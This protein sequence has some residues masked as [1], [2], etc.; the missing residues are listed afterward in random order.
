MPIRQKLKDFL[1]GK[2][3]PHHTTYLPQDMRDAQEADRPSHEFYNFVEIKGDQKNAQDELGALALA[4]GKSGDV[5]RHP[6]PQE[7][8]DPKA[9]FIPDG[10]TGLV[11][12]IGPSSVIVDVDGFGMYHFKPENLKQL[13]PAK[14]RESPVQKW[15]REVDPS[16][17]KVRDPKLYRI[18]DLYPGYE[19]PKPFDPSKLQKKKGGQGITLYHGSD[20][21]DIKVFNAST[22][23]RHGYFGS[24]LYTTPNFDEAAFYGRYVYEGAFNGC[25]YEADNFT[26][27]ESKTGDFDDV[28]N[29][30]F[31][32]NG[33]CYTTES[34]DNSVNGTRIEFNLNNFLSRVAV[35]LQNTAL[36]EAY[37]EWTHNQIERYGQM[38]V[39]EIAKFDAEEIVTEWIQDLYGND[40]TENDHLFSQ[41]VLHLMQAVSTAYGAIKKRELICID[42]TEIGMEVLAAGF[43]A[44]EIPGLEANQ[45]HTEI[46]VFDP[47][48]FVVH[49]VHD[50]QD[51]VAQRNKQVKKKGQEDPVNPKLPDETK[52]SPDW[53]DLTTPYAVQNERR[54]LQLLDIA[55]TLPTRGKSNIFLKEQ[56]VRATTS[57]LSEIK[58]AYRYEKALSKKYK[59][60]INLRTSTGEVVTDIH[61]GE[62]KSIVDA[63]KAYR[64]D[65]WR[66]A[67][68][69]LVNRHPDASKFLTLH[70]KLLRPL[71][72]RELPKP[73]LVE[74]D[75]PE[76]LNEN[77]NFTSLPTKNGG[78]IAVMERSASPAT[79]VDI[80][81][82]VPKSRQQEVAK[83]E[84]EVAER[85]KNGE[86]NVFYYW[87]MSRMP[88]RQPR[89]IYFVEDGAIRSYHEV[90]SMEADKIWMSP[91][92][93]AITPIPMK[94]FQGYRWFDGD[95][96]VENGTNR[97]ATAGHEA[98]AINTWYHGDTARRLTFEDQR[99]QSADRIGGNA[100]GPGIYF[101]DNKASANQYA[102]PNGY[103]YTAIIHGPFITTIQPISRP[104]LRRFLAEL[105]SDSRELLL[106]NWDPDPTRAEAEVFKTYR[107]M[108]IL[109]ALADLGRQGGYD[110]RESG[111]EWCAMMAR[112]TGA[113]GVVDEA[114]GHLSVWVPT[115]ITIT[116][117]EPYV[118]E[119]HERLATQTDSTTLKMAEI[120]YA[121]LYVDGLAE[122]KSELSKIPPDMR[123]DTLTS[124]YVGAYT[125]A[126]YAVFRYGHRWADEV[127]R[128]KEIPEKLF[129]PVEM[130]AR[131]FARQS[132]PKEFLK[133]FRANEKRL[134]LLAQAATWPERVDT[135]QQ[136]IVEGFE[137]HNT[138]GTSG[139]TLENTMEVI[140]NAAS[141]C[142]PYGVVYG[143]VYLV[144]QVEHANHAAW[145]KAQ[146]DIIYLRPLVK[147]SS[148]AEST[149]HLIHELGHR[150]WEKKLTA[151]QQQ[152]WTRNFNSIKHS[153]VK[154]EPSE[155]EVIPHLIVNKRKV[156]YGGAQAGFVS[157]LDAENGQLLGKV[158]LYDFSKWMMQVG[159]KAQFPTAYSSTSAEEYFAEAFSLMLTGSTL[160]EPHLSFLQKLFSPGSTTLK[161][162][163][164][165]N[166]HRRLQQ[167]RPRKQRPVP[168]PASLSEYIADRPSTFLSMEF[169][170]PNI[171][172][173]HLSSDPSELDMEELMFFAQQDGVT[174]VDSSPE[175]L[176]FQVPTTK[177][178]STTSPN[179]FWDEEEIEK[180]SDTEKQEVST[181]PIT[182]REATPEEFENGIQQVEQTALDQD[183]DYT[184]G[185]RLF[186]S[187]D[188]RAGYA[189][190]PDGELKWVWSTQRGYGK[191]AVQHALQNGARHLSAY[192]NGKLVKF[193]SGQGFAEYHREPNW[194]K[195]E[196]DVVFMRI[197]QDEDG[198]RQD[199]SSQ[200]ISSRRGRYNRR[201]RDLPTTASCALVRPYNRHAA[202]RSIKGRRLATRL[203]MAAAPFFIKSASSVKSLRKLLGS[204]Y[205][206]IEPAM[207]L[208]KGAGT[209]YGPFIIEYLTKT[210]LLEDLKTDALKNEALAALK[211]MTERIQTLDDLANRRD[212]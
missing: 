179:L 22:A 92:I 181:V 94:G 4:D 212:G 157:I 59:T 147:G 161:M 38:D 86:K 199:E 111:R 21:P 6:L 184:S 75:P 182:F 205:Q 126:K 174:L 202:F 77:W 82:T 116:A 24:G 172:S 138:I 102:Y 131:L 206:L 130:A 168:P 154:Y 123:D 10:M 87:Q 69:A 156:R 183:R 160:S 107:S 158:T 32:L 100:L 177:L 211:S 79:K 136:S 85:L 73:E 46:L 11:K 62:V 9:V 142:A 29:C 178:A 51:R 180:K 83:E 167:P 185:A 44:V 25:L 163:Q 97:F 195:G 170:R 20:D 43:D 96:I 37:A 72:N 169:I 35:L 114:R 5:K 117:E 155:G 55:A 103:V 12:S 88:K 192:D 140:K 58:A 119:R 65:D 194:T 125:N 189:I 187:N 186:I 196:P 203:T 133:W 176:H 15:T 31:C 132:P 108:P 193:Y 143:P 33:V 42:H 41:A 3:K 76:Y 121:K 120:S 78:V 191:P 47:A 81:V 1:I 64:S 101:T 210:S 60:P 50:T 23:G 19:G 129:K 16:E 45:G 2:D 137:V 52:G 98:E 198:R 106:S 28:W 80:V 159:E 127:I 71:Q 124:S 135:T 151:D 26:V 110:Y 7:I 49:K 165:M 48:K 113:T 13:K 95:A 40:D 204:H 207:K 84:Q 201:A 68:L 139:K 128:T 149:R 144:G 34:S 134:D 148:V 197:P 91:E 18:P 99:F 153:V 188:G 122:A 173:V 175:A 70:A 63:V 66:D 166:P 105:S 112:L 56:A 74:E 57:L 141:L 152:E 150:Y 93:H 30:Q 208:D 146:K 14:E 115:A 90:I 171:W 164:W 200:R 67:L 54:V 104:I 109:D 8:L 39:V 36:A 118:K 209:Q 17:V 145:Y 61:P 162:A 53:G 190:A 27:L 89:R